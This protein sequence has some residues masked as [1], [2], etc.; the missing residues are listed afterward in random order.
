MAFAYSF[1]ARLPSI[2]L[3]LGP[4][5]F[6]ILLFGSVFACAFESKIGGI[7]ALLLLI[8]LISVLTYAELGIQP[9]AVEIRPDSFVVRFL[10]KHRHYPF[11]DV[12]YII[13]D[14]IKIPRSG[15]AR[16]VRIGFHSWNSLQ[17][18]FPG[19][20]EQLYQNLVT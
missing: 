5:D 3:V 18:M 12:S 4:T 10:W 2:C 6:A 19:V 14:E 16:S 11:A 13:R 9:L 8:P 15:T 1:R 20:R 17:L 7:I